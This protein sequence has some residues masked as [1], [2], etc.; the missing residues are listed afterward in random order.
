MV[1]HPH[2]HLLVPIDPL[3][4]I[5]QR[6]QIAKALLLDVLILRGC[7]WQG[8]GAGARCR[9]IKLLLVPRCEGVCAGAERFP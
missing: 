2:S 7:W 9:E 4:F 5:P 8:V 1:I 3:R 6:V